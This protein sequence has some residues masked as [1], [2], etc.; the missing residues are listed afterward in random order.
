MAK[1]KYDGIIETVHY[2]PNGE[3]DWVRL[4]ERRGAIYSDYQIY[5][6]Q[7]LVDRMKAGKRFAAGKRIPYLANTFEVAS[8]LRLVKQDGKEVLVTD[9][10]QPGASGHDRLAG[11]PVV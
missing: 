7:K 3:V 8:A 6:R 1:V 11:V 5:D 4:F 2:K 10:A 9:Q